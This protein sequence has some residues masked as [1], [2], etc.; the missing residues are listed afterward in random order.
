M[1]SDISRE[2]PQDVN[3]QNPFIDYSFSQDK[4]DS[5]SK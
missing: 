3:I 1:R 5:G 2:L 4:K